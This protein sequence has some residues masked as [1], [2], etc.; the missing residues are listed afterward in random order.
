MAKSCVITENNNFRGPQRTRN[1]K[2]RSETSHFELVLIKSLNRKYNFL[3]TVS[4][5]F[6]SFFFL[7]ETGSD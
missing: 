1:K 3:E 2:N 6:L 4:N 5:W 7:E